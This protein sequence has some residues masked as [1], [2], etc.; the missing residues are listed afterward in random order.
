MGS[1]F[2][3]SLFIIG[4][5]TYIEQLINLP[6]FG[7][8]AHILDTILHLGFGLIQYMLHG[9]IS[10]GCSSSRPLVRYVNEAKS[11]RFHSS[12]NTQK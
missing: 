11:H 4:L 1:D 2:G 8:S 3:C 6:S 10:Q 7:L 5:V 9:K 12:A